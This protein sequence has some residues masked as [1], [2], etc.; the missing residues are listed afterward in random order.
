MQPAPALDRDHACALPQA[1]IGRW[2][3]AI[4]AGNRAFQSDAPI[5]ALEHYSTALVW[6]MAM[7]GRIADAHTGTAALVIA[8]HNLADT[9]AVLGRTVEQ[10]HHLCAA[11]ERLEAAIDDEDLAPAWRE[12]ALAHSRRTFTELT[13]FLAEHPD[14]AAALATHARSLGRRAPG[15]AH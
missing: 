8:H 6:A 10:A 13:R 2:R 3:Q 9:Y 15:R 12:A 7:Y 14:H 1:D 5:P 11:Q 4:S